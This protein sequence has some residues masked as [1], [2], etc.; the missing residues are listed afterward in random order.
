MTRD[1]ISQR[2]TREEKQSVNLRLR[3]YIDNITK[4]FGSK[5]MK[6]YGKINGY[7][8]NIRKIL[9]IYHIDKK[10]TIHFQADELERSGAL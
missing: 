2:K 5:L 9:I 8:K 7:C 3:I 4:S 1:R 10:I 6:C